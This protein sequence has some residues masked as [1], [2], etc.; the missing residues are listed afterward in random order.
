[1][2]NGYIVTDELKDIDNYIVP[3]SLNDKQGIMGAIQLAKWAKG[4]EN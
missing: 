4:I 2:L 3:A 1:M